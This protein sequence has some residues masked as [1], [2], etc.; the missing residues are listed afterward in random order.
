MNIAIIDIGTRATR[1]LIADTDEYDDNGFKFDYCYN[2]GSLTESGRGIYR[3]ENNKSLYKIE[4]LKST[5]E[6]I[7]ELKNICKEKRV[8]DD[9][10]F[11]VGTEVFRRVE[12]WKDMVNIIN[13]TCN[14]NLKVL[15]PKEEADCTFWAAVISCRE[16]YNVNEPI[17]V[18]EQGGGSMQLTIASISA[19]GK[20]NRYAQTSIPELGTLLLSERFLFHQDT[21][22]KV[23][24]VTRDVHNFAMEKIEHTLKS[25][26]NLAK[27]IT[28]TKGFALGSVITSFYKLSNKKIHGKE[29]ALEQIEADPIDNSILKQYNN[30]QIGSLLKDA[31][32]A[33]ISISYNELLKILEK[34]YGLPCY[35]SVMKFFN[36]KTVRICGTGLRYGI[37]F[38]IAH[39]EWKK[40]TEY[41][42]NEF[43]LYDSNY[44][45]I[46]SIKT[47]K[48]FE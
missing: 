14:L 32:N 17:L 20:P 27:D 36:L 34:G 35:S 38:K 18:I 11:A 43:K 6:Y 41:K 31:E 26:F 37:F 8:R 5:I 16:F 13:N 45:Q 23:G 12:N 24:T 10:I 44:P 29:I 46:A 48:R 25:T 1:L 15:D 9:N 4:N 33:Q 40:I 30:Y 39:K 47:N 3:G 7:L 42:G 2:W 21:P 22:R 19:I 28:P